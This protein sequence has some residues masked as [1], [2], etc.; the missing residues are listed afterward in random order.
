[1]IIR[2]K[3]DKITFDH[4]SIIF[5]RYMMS[6]ILLLMK[7]LGITRQGKNRAREVN[8]GNDSATKVTIKKSHPHNEDGFFECV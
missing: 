7:M 6:G 4:I 3:P 1:M 5:H 8:S 2:H